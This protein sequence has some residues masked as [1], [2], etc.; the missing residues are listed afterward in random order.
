MFPTAIFGHFYILTLERKNCASGTKETAL[1]GVHAKSNRP[2][3][4][5]LFNIQDDRGTH[6]PPCEPL[7]A[8]LLAKVSMYALSPVK[9][10]VGRLCE[11]LKSE[12]K[13]GWGIKFMAT[14]LPDFS[15]L[16]IVGVHREPGNVCI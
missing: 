9:A 7:C 4:R 1:S 6:V 13:S 8:I 10:N 14:T 11:K 5:D 16:L 2:A 15:L 12:M 3:S